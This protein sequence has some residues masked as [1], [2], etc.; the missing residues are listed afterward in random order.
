MFFKKEKFR[1]LT[2]AFLL[3]ILFSLTSCAT[4]YQRNLEFQE[5]FSQGDIERANKLLDKNEKDA[6]GK[7]K[8]LFLMKKGVV[9]QM[10]GQFEESNSYFEQAYI[11]IEDY[12]VN[13]GIEALSLLTNPSIRPYTGEDHE[14]VLIH[15]YKALNYLQL[16]QAQNAL[17]ECRRLNAK[18][19]A[20][21]DKYESKRNRFKDDAFAHNL[22]GIAY[23]LDG[24]VNNA[25]I[26]YRNAYNAYKG[27]Y[28]V[29]Y[30]IQ[31]PEQL[32]E[33]LMRTAYLNGFIEE[34]LR[35]KKEFGID[36]QYKPKKGGELVFFWH[37][38]LGPVKDE[39]SINF[40]IVR[41]Q[42][43]TATFVNEELGLSFPY[44]IPQSKKDDPKGGLGDLKL[45]RVAFPKYLARNP[46]FTSAELFT[47][48]VTFYP[49]EPVENIEGIAL[50]I[51]EDRMLREIT[52]SIA[53]LALKQA[54]EY[55]LREENDGMGAVLSIVNALTEKADTRNWQTLPNTI[56]YS[57][58]PLKKGINKVEIKT[59][60]PQNEKAS[61]KEAFEFEII[62]NETIFHIYN[63]LESYAPAGY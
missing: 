50:S 19:N 63:S 58:V 29:N 10:L 60:S 30:G 5:S 61:Q 43:G 59:Y 12:K 53:R 47:D 44:I 39:W 6:E 52:T 17:V 33:D 41:G 7:N 1:V 48:S 18:L 23:E 22:M 56:H 26:A 8:L 51:L 20:L 62:E 14:K 24:D 49:L 42:N 4:Y 25:F 15:Y 46:Y 34:L 38:G 21:N 55:A 2:G 11:F 32:K 27:S 54:S 31:A 13:Y 16:N 40:T 45:I 3:P 28:S 37:N 9:T 57:R 36:Y 35:Y